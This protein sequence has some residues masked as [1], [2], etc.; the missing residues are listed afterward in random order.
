[1]LLWKNNAKKSVVMD[2]FGMLNVSLSM[3]WLYCII[4]LKDATL[5]RTWVRSM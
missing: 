4:V 2:M 3:Y 1:M 5:G